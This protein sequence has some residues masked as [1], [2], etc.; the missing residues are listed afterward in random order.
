MKVPTLAYPL[1]KILYP[2]HMLHFKAAYKSGSRR[3]NQEQTAM[4][5]AQRAIAHN[6]PRGM[7]LSPIRFPQQLPTGIGLFFYP[8]HTQL[9]QNSTITRRSHVEVLTHNAGTPASEA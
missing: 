6:S 9:L 1:R 2:T 8:I 3:G 7:Y 5:T 4:N